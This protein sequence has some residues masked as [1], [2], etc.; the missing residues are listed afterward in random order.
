[1]HTAAVVPL[2]Y[3]SPV[4]TCVYHTPKS[5]IHPYIQHASY[6]LRY[7]SPLCTTILY[8]RLTSMH[9]VPAYTA[10]SYVQHFHMSHPRVF[11][12]HRHASHLSM[13]HTFVCTTNPYDLAFHKLYSV[14]SQS[15]TC[16]HCTTPLHVTLSYVSHLPMYHT[17]LTHFCIYD[18]LV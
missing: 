5:T 8:V 15:Q 2:Q 13:Y 16:R 10:H 3:H 12:V 7:C 1:M 17:P 4:H 11:S 9:Y 18:I 6:S 14:L